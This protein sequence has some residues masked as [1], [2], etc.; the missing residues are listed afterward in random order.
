MDLKESFVDILDESRYHL[1]PRLP[2]VY[3][4]GNQVPLPSGPHD[5]PFFKVSQLCSNPEKIY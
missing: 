2:T 1:E 4:L 5:G 3:A